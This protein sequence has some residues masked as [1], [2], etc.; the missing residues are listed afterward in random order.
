MVRPP[1]KDWTLEYNRGNPTPKYKL[2]WLK[3]FSGNVIVQPKYDGRWGR[4]HHESGSNKMIL[5]SRHGKVQKQIVKSEFC[6]LDEF[7]LHGE[8]IFGTSFA[9]NSPLE[10]K[11][12]VFDL[13]PNDDWSRERDLSHRLAYALAHVTI[14][15]Q[16]GID[17]I[18]MIESDV[19]MDSSDTY[20]IDDVLSGNRFGKVEGV[21][22]KQADSLYG[23][24]WVRIK[25]IYDVDYVVMGFNHSEAKSF[26]GKAIKSIQAGL[27][28]NGELTKVCSVGGMSL[29]ERT[30]MY[31]NPMNYIGEVFTASGKDVFKSGA[32]RHP[33]FVRMHPEKLAEECKGVNYD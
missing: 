8:Y 11:L 20:V 15:K 32:L 22:L 29:A 27:Y 17:W 25:P 5:W 21:V 31:K 18:E 2:N 10:N 16:M 3:L 30:D 13:E 19:M 26:K 9:K 28:I 6:D 14:L 4:L 33:N 7:T 24:T 12:I 23:D 1:Y